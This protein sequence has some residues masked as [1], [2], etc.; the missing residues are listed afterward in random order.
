MGG[1]FTWRSLAL[2]CRGMVA[3]VTCRLGE[4]EAS[5]VRV[6]RPWFKEK[7]FMFT[8]VQKRGSW[9]PSILTCSLKKSY[10]TVTVI[11][12]IILTTS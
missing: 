5:T 2:G 11:R 12:L 1:G 4:S 6:H 7:V 3:R 8:V 9:L 10:F